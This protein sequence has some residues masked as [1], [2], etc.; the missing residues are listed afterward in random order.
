MPKT[1]PKGNSTQVTPEAG[2]EKRT[3]RKFAVE[4]K[5]QIIAAANACK[6]GEL[7]A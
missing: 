7:G 2:L 3:R 1:T 6:R 4:Y 5:L